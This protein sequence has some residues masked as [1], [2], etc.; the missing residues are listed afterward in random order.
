MFT[1]TTVDNTPPLDTINPFE[2]FTVRLIGPVVCPCA[3]EIVPPERFELSVKVSLVAVTTRLTV[4]VLEIEPD[5][6]LTV[7][8]VVPPAVVTGIP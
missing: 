8:V 2:L 1:G 6:P 7:T 4:V 3:T 5:T